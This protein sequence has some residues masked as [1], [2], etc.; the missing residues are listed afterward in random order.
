MFFAIKL[1]RACY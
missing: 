1:K